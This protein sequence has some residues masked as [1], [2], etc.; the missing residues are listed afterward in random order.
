M[1]IP[2]NHKV[3]KVG[4]FLQALMENA[5]KAWNLGEH[6]S[7]DEQVVLCN[8]RKCSYKQVL[9]HKKYNG[10]LLYSVNDP[11][12]GYTFAFE[13]DRRNNEEGGR[14]GFA[15]RLCEYISGEWRRVWMDSA[16]PTIRGLEAMYDMGIYGG[17][18]IKHIMGFPA[19]LDELKRP[20]GDKNPVLKKG[21]Y[22]WRM[23]PMKAKADGT[24]RKAAFTAVIWHDVGYAKI[25][26]TCH[27][28]NA[29]MVKR[30][31]SGVQGRV[32]RPCLESISEY[33]KNMGGTD[34][35]DQLRH[36]NTTQRKTVKWWHAL[37]L[38]ALDVASGVNA[39]TE[40]Q[41][42]YIDH[43]GSKLGMLTRQKFVSSIA[44][45]LLG[46]PQGNTKKRRK[47]KQVDN[48]LAVDGDPRVRCEKARLMVC[49]KRNCAL[50]YRKSPKE[51]KK[52]LP[53]RTACPGCNS[54]LHV[55]CY[56]E[57]HE[58]YCHV[59]AEQGEPVM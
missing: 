45:D 44:D 59:V 17:G 13:A 2:P 28:P 3:R 6:A 43:N 51:L 15:M 11:V 49:P 35:C 30:R 19:E 55:E 22:E 58:D 56:D 39:Y 21:E 20:M 16:F 47:S 54:A 14:P 34:Q 5:Q 29:T 31:Q 9:K 50:C 36:Y 7:I 32:D 38:W 53:V 23:A 48:H 40:Y 41:Y 46:E 27:Q 52:Q 26:T 18:T 4:R 24:E 42:D 25:I 8:S 10:I 33:N 1:I 12:T 37:F 57:W